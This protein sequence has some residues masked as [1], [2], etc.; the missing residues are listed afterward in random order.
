MR[1]LSEIWPLLTIALTLLA[2]RSSQADIVVDGSDQDATQ[3]GLQ[4]DFFKRL[5]RSE[6]EI[7]WQE[8]SNAYQAPNR[9]HNL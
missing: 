4:P 9:S 1:Y 3:F 2:A 5:E 8:E 7:H 6:Y